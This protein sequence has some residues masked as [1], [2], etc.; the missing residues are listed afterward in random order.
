M[1]T[2]QLTKLSISGSFKRP[3][4]SVRTTERSNNNSCARFQ[5][6]SSPSRIDDVQT[7]STTPRQSDSDSA[8]TTTSTVRTRFAEI[9]KLLRPPV[10]PE[11]HA[12]LIGISTL[13]QQQQLAKLKEKEVTDQEDQQHEEVKQNVS[14]NEALDAN[15]VIQSAFDSHDEVNSP[16]HQQQQQLQQA[17][18]ELESSSR[19]SI[20]LPMPKSRDEYSILLHLFAYSN[21]KEAAI[22]LVQRM[23]AKN[24]RLR[25]VDFHHVIQL[26]ARLRRPTRADAKFAMELLNEMKWTG[27][28]PRHTTYACVLEIYSRLGMQSEA[29]AMF[30]EIES[31]QAERKRQ[32]QEKGLE[33]GEGG[34]G[35]EEDGGEAAHGYE[36]YSPGA[37]AYSSLI[38]MYAALNAHTEAYALWREMKA[39]YG[40][41]PSV[42]A[43][44]ALLGMYSRLE[45]VPVQEEV[46]N[47]MQ[48]RFPRPNAFICNLYLAVC[49]RSGN[50]R[51]ALDTLRE[52]KL[53]E[54]D[55]SS[56]DEEVRLQRLKL[57]HTADR[58]LIILFQSLESEQ[59]TEAVLYL[60]RLIEEGKIENDFK[61]DCIITK[62]LH[63]AADDDLGLSVAG[64]VKE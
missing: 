63:E 54:K 52:V 35:E 64:G 61:L 42:S 28:A 37:R 46:M 9:R 21:H 5:S 11:S 60:K 14:A 49:A 24:T 59:R 18:D 50:W 1:R 51:L 20:A 23:R 56:A 43:Y 40:L 62:Y 25:N 15:K 7:D 31:L 2:K 29:L 36:S 19:S 12:M 4:S 13:Y 55:L 48:K 38:H 33:R 39:T 58:L 6:G 41:F 53:Q 30:R 17:A 44:Q 45:M 27:V 16:T 3:I 47:E 57:S 22:V 34:G 8:T 10:S 26:Y 32:V